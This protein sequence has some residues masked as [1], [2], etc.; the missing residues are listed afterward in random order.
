MRLRAV[1]HAESAVGGAHYG[2]GGELRDGDV[3]R[4]SVRSVRAEGHD[5]SG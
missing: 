1:V 5:T 4:V 2:G 3:V